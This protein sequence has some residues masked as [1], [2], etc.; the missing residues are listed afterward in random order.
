M[1][2][3]PSSEQALNRA[4]D[5]VESA[6]TAVELAALVVIA[7]AIGSVTPESTYA[8]MRAREARDLKAIESALARGRKLLEARSDK[9]MRSI[10]DASDE[11]SAKFYKAAGKNPVKASKHDGMKQAID[12]GRKSNDDAIK[13]LCRTS[14]LEIISP[15]GELL[16]VAYAYRAHVDNAIRAIM[17]GDDVYQDAISKAVDDLAEYGLRV[18]YESGTTRELYA[19]VRT[20]VMDGYRMAMDEVR[21]MH[22][23]E[24]GADGVEITAHSLCA[25]DHQPYQGK[26]YSNS[27]FER[28]NSTLARPISSHNCHHSTFPVIIGV[29]SETYPDEQLQK[30]IDASNEEVSFIGA[31]GKKL[32]MTRYE[33][34][35]YQRKIEGNIRRSNMA[36]RLERSAGA[37]TDAKRNAR[38]MTSYY[39]AMCRDAGLSTRMERTQAYVMK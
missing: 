13:R 1:E 9:L 21:D 3:D 31:G 39:T 19:A 14:V 20:N 27:E 33:A 38:D 26:Q 35:Q 4:A 12:F 22:G 10:A 37:S 36:T 2:K 25:P 23:R 30:M 16:P 17:S 6:A 28:L 29:S 18:R 11:W 24:F 5:S 15:D 8:S 7:A 34:T 32:T